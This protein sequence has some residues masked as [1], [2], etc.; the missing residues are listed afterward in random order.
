MIAGVVVIVQAKRLEQR[1]DPSEP[2]LPQ[3]GAGPPVE[4][5]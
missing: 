4:S 2:T 1:A 3:S 5:P